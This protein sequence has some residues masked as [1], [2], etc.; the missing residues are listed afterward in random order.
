MTAMTVF[1][2]NSYK[3]FERKCLI[4]VQSQQ[5]QLPYCQCIKQNSCLGSALIKQACLVCLCF[6]KNK[7]YIYIYILK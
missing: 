1:D 4:K 5:V 2:N 7:L 3:T 6:H